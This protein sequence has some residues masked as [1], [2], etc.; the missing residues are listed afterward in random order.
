MRRVRAV[1][2]LLWCVFALLTGAA[3]FWAGLSFGPERI[4]VV[5]STPATYT[6]AQGTVGNRLQFEASGSWPQ[7]TLA[8]AGAGG[9]VTSVDVPKDLMV[10]EGQRVLSIGLRP[11]VVLLGSVPASRD[12]TSDL[13]GPDVAQLQAAL[14]RAGYRAPK[15]GRYDAAT[16]RAVRAWQKDA[17]FGVDGVVRL[18]DVVFLPTLPTRVGVSAG[19]VTGARVAE[20][21][22]LIEGVVGDAVTEI[23]V[24]PEQAALIPTDGDVT[25]SVGDRSWQGRFGDSWSDA[26]AQAHIPVVA[27]GG[28]P[29]CGADCALVLPMGRVS[30]IRVDVVDV[31]QATGAVVPTSALRTD[32]AGR[33]SVAGADGLEIGVTVRASFGGLAVVDG[34]EVGTSILV[35][36]R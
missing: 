16:Q 8:W 35:F 15:T 9:V 29:V 22:A 6:V 14:R 20:G 18:G 31:P 33:V 28:G 12:L 1:P 34:V 13:A 30:A 21:A 26:D 36:G 4:D 23:V 27:T 7:A 24:S 17:G 25:A 3:G 5:S 10:D 2:V 32:P 19:V 11:V